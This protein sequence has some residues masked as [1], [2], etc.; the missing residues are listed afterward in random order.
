MGN[1]Y[2]NINSHIHKSSTSCPICGSEIHSSA[3]FCDIC[4]MR[5]H[6]HQLQ[7]KHNVT[8]RLNQSH[9]ISA[10]IVQPTNT[11]FGMH[12]LS[13]RAD[14]KIVID[15][16]KSWVKATNSMLDDMIDDYR[17][18]NLDIIRAITTGDVTDTE[19]FETLG[20]RFIE[21]RDFGL[22]RCTKAAKEIFNLGVMMSW[23]NLSERQRMEISGVYAKEVAE[24]F[25]LK[26]YSGV[27]YEDLE[28][29]VY[30]YNNGNGEIYLSNYLMEPQHSPFTII[31][32]ITHELRHQ[33]QFEAIKGYHNIPEDVAKEWSI[34]F[35]IYHNDDTEP[36]CYDPWGYH[37]SPIEID[38]RYAGETVVR[39][40]THDLFNAKSAKNGNDINMHQL[41]ESLI[42]EGY[43][44]VI[45]E[46]T[47][48]NL[49]KLEGKAAE[50]L[51]SW[52]KSGTLPEFGD[53]EGFNSSI[54]R[55][56]FRMKEPAIILSYALLLNNPSQNSKFL[57]NMISSQSKRYMTKANLRSTYL[58]YD[59]R[60]YNNAK[61]AIW[62]GNSQ[63][64]N[65]L[66]WYGD[67][68]YVNGHD[69]AWRV[70]LYDDLTQ[71]ELEWVVGHIREHSGQYY[72]H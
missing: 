23:A 6:I 71:E 43:S 52:L 50:L 38:A 11:R 14:L 21:E 70:D 63:I 45:L 30:G 65:K 39:N 13:E 62:N 25:E 36:C 27:S 20:A 24:A 31:D 42:K 22:D 35:Q 33:Y 8:D 64:H 56:D 12:T 18:R 29:E 61:D 67:W 69:H 54:L 7:A 3:L 19:I 48:E 53:I 17:K 28:E 5:I 59:E 15:G 40:I 1:T 26:L 34:A 68:G 51:H 58:F 10:D 37:Y 72:L 4:G 57:K 9:I 46:H 66:Y 2:K 41:K 32:T 60:D 49:Q 16:C 47:I 55:K 44:G